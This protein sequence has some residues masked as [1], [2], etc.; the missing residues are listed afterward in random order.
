M[1][2]GEDSEEGKYLGT[3]EE[4]ELYTGLDKVVGS[5]ASG[6]FNTEFES[7]SKG[8]ANQGCLTPKYISLVRFIHIL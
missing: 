7:V 2:S 5:A 6:I 1:G 8:N 3:Q 4:D